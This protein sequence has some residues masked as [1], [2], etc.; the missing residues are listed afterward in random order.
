[1]APHPRS[2][3]EP[4]VGDLLILTDDVYDESEVWGSPV[5]TGE[6]PYVVVGIID[7]EAVIRPRGM[8]DD[9]RVTGAIAY[10]RCGQVL[11]ARCIYEDAVMLARR[12]KRIL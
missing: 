5:L 1:M 10:E 3:S 4:T 8:L 12:E 6:T 9:W 2:E 7:R 11:R